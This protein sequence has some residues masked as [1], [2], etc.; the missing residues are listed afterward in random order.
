MS[1]I[2]AVHFLVVSF[3]GNTQHVFV[4]M[5]SL[6]SS[7]ATIFKWHREITRLTWHLAW[8][9]ALNEM[10]Y[11]LDSSIWIWLTKAW[12]FIFILQHIANSLEKKDTPIATVAKGVCIYFGFGELHVCNDMQFTCTF[13]VAFSFCCFIIHFFVFVYNDNSRGQKKSASQNK[14]IL[15]GAYHAS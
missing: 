8:A 15:N 12:I 9:F 2:C 3:T 6:S 13:N 5:H 7:V 10:I 11:D 1:E 14:Y 4:L